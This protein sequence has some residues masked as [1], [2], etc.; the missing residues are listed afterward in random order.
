[1]QPSEDPQHNRRAV[2]GVLHLPLALCQ[3]QEAGNASISELA[4]KVAT[5]WGL[6]M[7]RV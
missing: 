4:Q 2:V 5:L 3:M 6:G 7:F 1:M